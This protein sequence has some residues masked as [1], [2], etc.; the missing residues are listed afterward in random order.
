MN[1]VPIENRN[2][3]QVIWAHPRT[4]S[5]TAA[6]AGDVIG[7]LRQRKVNVETLDIYRSGFDPLLREIDEPELDNLNKQYS[8]EVML[9]ASRAGGAAAV[10]FAFPVWWF[11]VHAALKGYIERVWNYGIFYGDGRRTGLP[12][13]RWI[14][15]AGD[16]E[17]NFTKRGYDRMMAHHLNQGI[18]GFCGAKDSRLDLLCNTFADNVEDPVA[19]FTQLRAQARATAV[20]LAEQIGTRAAN[21]DPLVSDEEI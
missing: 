9:S 5:F 12:T 3:V 1:E 21:C 6:I 8:P 13:V 11:S 19:H 7:E 15:L 16:P 17:R 4:D 18:A 2:T 20:E 14:G 10:V